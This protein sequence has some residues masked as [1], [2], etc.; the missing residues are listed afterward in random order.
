MKKRYIART[1]ALLLVVALLFSLAGQAL[2]VGPDNSNVVGRKIVVFKSGVTSEAA[3]EQIVARAGAAKIKHL[4]IV[5]ATVVIANPASERALEQLPEVLRVEPD[6]LA[7]TQAE[8]LAWGVDRVD[9]E[10]VWDTDRNLQ[11]DPGAN[12]GAGVKVAVIDTGIDLTHPDLQANIKGGYNAIDPSKSA[13]DDNGHGS[14]VAG[15]IAAVD[16]TAGVIGVAPQA[17]LYAVKALD[18]GGS[19][20]WSDIIEGVQWSVSNGMQ[21]INMSLGAKSAPGALHD[22]IIAAYNSGIVIVAAAGNSGPKPGSVMYPAKYAEVIAVAATDSKDAVPKFSS[23]GPEVEIAAPGASVYSTYKNGGYA[24]LSGTSMASP[25]VAG[26][27]A[28]VIAS[29]RA[30]G[31]NS[32]RTILQTTADEKGTAGRD[33]LYGYGLLDAQEAATGVETLP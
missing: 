15:I 30:S 5:N 23:R 31:A 10:K 21:V 13:N 1:S 3:Q 7:F 20:Y 25:H 18:S 32:V 8:T 14:H 6:G 33:S 27:A 28:L 9:A 17:S 26:A 16:N 22:A 2:A 12:V 29:G 4:Q 24:T 11:V 19:G